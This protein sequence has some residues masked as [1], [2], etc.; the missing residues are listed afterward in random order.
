MN[1]NLI[2]CYRLAWRSFAKWWIPLC[3]LSGVMVVFQIVPRIAMQSEIQD[4]RAS[5]KALVPAVWTGDVERMSELVPLAA[6]QLQLLTRRMLV[7]TAYLF[8]FVALLTVLLLMQANRAV[9]NGADEP[10]SFLF[11]VYVAVMHVAMAVVKAFAF[12]FFAVP[13]VFLYVKLLFASLI[14]L[15]EKKGAREAIAMSWR[16]TTGNFWPLLAL[17]LINVAIQMLVLPTVIGEIPATGFVNTA[18]AAA[19][20]MLR[21]RARVPPPVPSGG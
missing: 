1:L 3:L 18:R 7:V 20:R 16:M 19:F 9:K 13:G 6:E 15:E 11:L 4:L 2:G 10:K 17:V 5:L 8:P 21:E 14:M 12:F